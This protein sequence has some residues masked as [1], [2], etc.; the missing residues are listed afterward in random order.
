MKSSNKSSKQEKDNNS[1]VSLIILVLIVFLLF[2]V[3]FIQNGDEKGASEGF[4]S[5]SDKEEIAEKLSN[6]CDILETQDQ[7]RFEKSKLERNKSYALKLKQQQ[8]EIK[9]LENII[10]AMKDHTEERMKRND[11]INM[12]RAEKM[13]IDTNKLKL[14][15]NNRL[16]DQELHTIDTQIN[17]N[18]KLVD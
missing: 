12:I 14:S 6:V 10:K 18:P 15:L 1:M 13:D 2:R 17:L 4:K 11:V 8:D 16:K 3:I 7:I 9:K 5:N